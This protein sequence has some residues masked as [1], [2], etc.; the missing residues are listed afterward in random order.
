MY[1]DT[2]IFYELI[3][4]NTVQNSLVNKNLRK[5]VVATSIPTREQ[6][7]STHICREV[8]CGS[9]KFLWIDLDLETD[10]H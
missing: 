7:L 6:N 9:A 5:S 10:M 1:T 4:T 2:R 3:P 8:F